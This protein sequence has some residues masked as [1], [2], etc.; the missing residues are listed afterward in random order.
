MQVADDRVTYIATLTYIY[1]DGPW[2][3]SLLLQYVT[4]GRTE[5][6]SL[7]LQWMKWKVPPV[8]LDDY[9]K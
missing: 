1:N 2:D 4:Q 7:Q 3:G 6:V 5:G 9:F 8:Q